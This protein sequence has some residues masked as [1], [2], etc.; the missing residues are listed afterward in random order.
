M[1]KTLMLNPDVYLLD[2][3]VEEAK[4]Q[5]QDASEAIVSHGWFSTSRDSSCRD[6]K[7]Q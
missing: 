4:K 7:L 3:L 6:C 1:A 2:T 5:L